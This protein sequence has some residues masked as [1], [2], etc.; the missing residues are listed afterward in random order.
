[1][2]AQSLGR[3]DGGVHYYDYTPET[4]RKVDYKDAYVVAEAFIYDKN[5]TERVAI[6][7]LASGQELK[8]E[9]VSRD[10][11]IRRGEAVRAQAVATHRAQ[12]PK[13][14]RAVV[15]GLKGQ[16]IETKENER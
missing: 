7:V 4:F 2:P 3:W 11:A 15:Y 6:T 8:I 12:L 9:G 10:D 5:D 1:M 16:V 14:H 13:H